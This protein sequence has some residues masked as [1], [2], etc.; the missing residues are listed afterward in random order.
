MFFLIFILIFIF[1]I[2]M[3]IKIVMGW[4]GDLLGA[5][6]GL[7]GKAV[8]GSVLPFAGLGSAIGGL[9][10]DQLGNLARKIPFKRGGTV[11]MMMPNGQMMMVKKKKSSKK[12]RGKK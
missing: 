6:L 9:A 3:Y 8:G 12:R 7:G 5:G 10:G 2:A 4:F 1:Y 11:A